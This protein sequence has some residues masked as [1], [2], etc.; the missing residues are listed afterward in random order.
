MGLD[1][2]EQGIKHDLVSR[3]GEMQPI[4]QEVGE[5]LV[6]RR[7][8]APYQGLFLAIVVVLSPAGFGHEH[9]PQVERGE[10]Q[11]ATELSTG[12]GVGSGVGG[13]SLLVAELPLVHGRRGDED[14]FGVVGGDPRVVD[15]VSEVTRVGVQR[16]VLR[17]TGQGGIVGPKE[18]GHQLH[19]GS[20]VVGR[21]S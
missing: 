9:G 8:F 11:I 15:D 6:A 17:A 7:G 1:E 14:D 10:T 5:D 3:R 13:R 12:G 16:D 4:R 2:L 18:Q 19:L 20:E 21:G